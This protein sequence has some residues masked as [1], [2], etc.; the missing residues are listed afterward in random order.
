[1]ILFLFSVLIS[2]FARAEIDKPARKIDDVSRD[3]IKTPVKRVSTAKIVLADYELI[4][5]DFSHARNLSNDQID[6]WLLNSVAFVA[7]TQL[8][9][10]EVNTAISLGPDARTAYRPPQYGRALVFQV[11]GGFID[12]KGVGAIYPVQADHSNGLATLGEVL[13]EYLYQKMV[14]LLFDH[15]ESNLKTVGSYAVI[16][17]GFHV[18]HSDGSTSPAGAILRQ[19]H[20]RFDNIS[21]LLT[22]DQMKRFERVLRKY[23]V[24]S[25]GAHRYTIFEKANIQGTHNS[26]VVDF[27]AFLTVDQFSKV[28]WDFL[29]DEVIFD[30]RQ[31]DFIQPHDD[32]RVPLHIWGTTHS[33]VEDPKQDNPWIWSHELAVALSQGLATREDVERH[34][35]NLLAP[36][37]QILNSKRCVHVLTDL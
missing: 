12:V 36:V 31:P 23:G 9:R 22:P 24:T 15:D 27:G 5:K 13:R 4:R 2:V 30:P 11:K 29:L 19:A 1:M 6:S 37:A 32:L 25:A 34:A 8:N 16:D 7:D 26:E 18:I 10:N 14:Q 17:W 35:K 3:I 20:R 33:L 21:S 28:V